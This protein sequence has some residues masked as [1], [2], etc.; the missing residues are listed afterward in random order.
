MGEGCF[1]LV[2]LWQLCESKTLGAAVARSARQV[3][4]FPLFVESELHSL[5]ELRDFSKLLAMAPLKL[6]RRHQKRVPPYESPRKS[7]HYH[8]KAGK[9]R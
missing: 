5:A 3:I 2:L 4:L 7:P 6:S 1:A 8:F 9:A